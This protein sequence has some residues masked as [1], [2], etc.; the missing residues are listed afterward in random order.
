M[1]LL[2]NNTKCVVQK[3]ISFLSR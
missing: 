1:P 3:M 2:E